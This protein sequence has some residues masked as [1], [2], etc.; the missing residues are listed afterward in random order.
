MGGMEKAVNS[1]GTEEHSNNR[2][3]L[4]INNREIEDN[5]RKGIFKSDT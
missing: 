5:D 1:R 3:E 4:S 2:K